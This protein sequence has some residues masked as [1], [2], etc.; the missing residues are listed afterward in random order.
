MASAE[1]DLND[2]TKIEQATAEKDS[3]TATKAKKLEAKATASGDLKDTTATKQADEKYLADLAAT[4]EQKAYDFEA[5][6]QLRAVELEA[7]NKAIEIIASG[8]VSGKFLQ[9]RAQELNSRDDLDI[10]MNVVLNGKEF[11]SSDD[12]KKELDNKEGINGSLHTTI[13][14]VVL[15]ETLSALGAKVHCN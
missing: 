15:M 13:Q 12:K 3:K 8:A 2:T 6:Q 10:F 5:R 14:T 11:D 1:G 7:I 4:C 9:Q